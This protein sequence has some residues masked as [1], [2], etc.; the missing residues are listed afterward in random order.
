[1]WNTIEPLWLI[2]MTKCNIIIHDD[3][4]WKRI[5]L[6]NRLI[7][8]SLNFNFR[9]INY[10]FGNAIECNI[11]ARN[12]RSK[13]IRKLKRYNFHIIYSYIYILLRRRLE[14]FNIYIYMH[15]YKDMCV[16]NLFW[17]IVRYQDLIW[18]RVIPMRFLTIY[19]S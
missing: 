12:T 18:F 3:I 9:N 17:Y 2:M 6:L 5:S 1:M 8:F 4:M 16:F 13:I 7:V 10:I 19:A 15:L 14:R 11:R